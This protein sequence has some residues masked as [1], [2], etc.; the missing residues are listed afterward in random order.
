MDHEWDRLCRAKR[1]PTEQAGLYRA[2]EVNTYTAVVNEM[3]VSTHSGW[4]HFL[5]IWTLLALS[6]LSEGCQSFAVFGENAVNDCGVERVHGRIEWAE[7]QRDG[8]YLCC[9]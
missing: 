2:P 3:Y 1:T 6:L 8:N 4:Y 5:A 7:I 9:I